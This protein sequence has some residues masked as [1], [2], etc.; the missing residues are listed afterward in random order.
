MP[1]QHITSSEI[2]LNMALLCAAASEVSS[3]NVF[4]SKVEFSMKHWKVCLNHK[5]INP[6]VL[7]LNCSTIFL[8]SS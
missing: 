4:V 2:M 5:Y 7:V 6:T 1:R 8:A 3:N